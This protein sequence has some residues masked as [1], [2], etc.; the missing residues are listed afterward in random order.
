MVDANARVGVVGA[1]ILGKLVSFFLLEAGLK[2]TVFEEGPENPKN[3][4]FS[5][6][7]AAAGMIA[8]YCE[9][10]NRGANVTK[11]GFDSLEMWPSIVKRVGGNVF[12]QRE[13]SLVVA[14]SQD[15]NE[16]QRLRRTVESFIAK[17]EMRVVRG[18]EIREYEPDLD[19]KMTEGLFF[20]LEGQIDGAEILAALGAHLRANGATLN[21]NAK[22]H[23]V[24]AGKITTDS[25]V[26]G[27]DCV[28]DCRGMGAKADLKNLR[29]VRGEILRLHAQDVSL[30][31]PVR[32]MHPRYPIYVVPRPN[33]RGALELLSALYTLNTGFS[34]ARITEAAVQLRPAFLDNAPRIFHK[35]GLCRA[36][37]L[38][39]HGYLSSPK[40]AAL[41]AAFVSEG[42]IEKGYES[43]FEQEK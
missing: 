42:R 36:N 6:S 15:K 8:P 16:L 24:E 34:E 11:L 40:L 41:T 37:G 27:F 28:V 14:H 1:G 10:E 32:L 4:S 30:K 5:A 33:H 20:P 23:K 2:P 21:F 26:H 7:Y 43:L 25:G 18:D 3:S 31:R 39:R 9:L 17:P 12:F 38:F 29:G 19:P 22:A 35:K 13:G